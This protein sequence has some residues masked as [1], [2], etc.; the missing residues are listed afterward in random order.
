MHNIFRAIYIEEQVF[1]LPLTKQVVGKLKGVPVIPVRHYKDIFNRPRQN[2][3]LQ[4][5]EPALLLSAQT[6]Q[7]FYPGPAICQSFGSDR[8]FYAS[9]LQNCLFDCQYCFLQGMYPSA[10]LLAFMNLHTY[11]QA[12]VQIARQGPAYIAL[13]HDADL[14]SCHS[15]VPYLNSIS[16]W[17][18]TYEGLTF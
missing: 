2:L 1:S 3:Y 9:L 8:F 4:K 10:D 13:S 16:H 5:E 18:Q 14:L 17:W 6:G 11:E 12:L 15:F 7:P